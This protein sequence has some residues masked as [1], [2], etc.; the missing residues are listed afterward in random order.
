MC[1]KSAEKPEQHV[2]EEHSLN[3]S[4]EDIQ[5]APSSIRYPKANLYYAF[6]ED[7]HPTTRIAV[8]KSLQREKLPPLV[9]PFNETVQMFS[10]AD[11]AMTHYL[12]T[13]P[14]SFVVFGKPGLNSVDLASAIADAWNCILISPSLLIQEEIDADSE[15]GRCMQKTLEKGEQ[16]A[17]D[18]VMNL[19][20]C[21]IQKRDVRHRGYVVEGL[22]LIPD[23]T[24]FEDGQSESCKDQLICEM[25]DRTVSCHQSDKLA[26]HSV[27]KLQSDYEQQIPQQ[28]DEIFNKLQR[29]PSIIIY[30][31]CPK[32][33]VVIMREHAETAAADTVAED[34]LDEE[35]H[36]PLDVRQDTKE[37]PIVNDDRRNNYSERVPDV[38]RE[39]ELQC[40]LYTRLALPTI[41]KWILAHDP[42]RVIRV[43]GRGSTQRMFQTL[44]ACLRMLPLQPSI[45]PKQMTVEKVN[46]EEGH[47]EIF[48]ILRQREIVSAEFPWRLSAWKFFCPVKLALGQ[49]E[50]RC[51]EYTVRFL[52]YIFFLSSQESV[53]LFIEN[54]RTFLLPPNPQPICKIAVIGP[55]YSGK[56]E[57]S[58][59]LAKVFGGTVI[60]VNELLRN[61]PNNIY[62]MNIDEYD[63]NVRNYDEVSAWLCNAIEQNIK[64]IPREE[65]EDELYKDGGY[66]VD[67]IPIYAWIKIFSKI[68]FMHV[69]VLFEDAYTS[70]TYRNSFVLHTRHSEY[71]NT[72]YEY[73]RDLNKMNKYLQTLQCNTFFINLANIED[74]TENVLDNLRWNFK[75]ATNDKKTETLQGTTSTENNIDEET[76]EDEEE[77][78]SRVVDLE[79]AERLLACGYYFL[80]PFGRWCPVQMYANVIL[81]AHSPNFPFIYQSQIYFLSGEEALLAFS[82]EI[83]KYLARGFRLPA[84]PLRIA[85]IGPPKCGKT[86]LAD[87]FAKTYGLKRITRDIALRH[88]LKHYSWTE[89]AQVAKEK[90]QANQPVPIEC[91]IRAIEALSLGPRAASQGYVLDD[92]PLSREE[93]E[94]LILSGIQPMIVLDLKADLPSCLNCL[95]TGSND[96]TDATVSSDFLARYETWQ[97]H[98]ASFRDWLKKFSRNVVELDAT[99]SKWRVWSVADGAVRL[100][101]AEIA[102]YQ[103]DADLDKVHRLR[104]MCVSPFEFRERQSQ[105]E[106][107][108]PACLFRE[109]VVQASIQPT[110]NQGVV[111]YQEHFYWVCPQHMAA[112]IEDPWQ[113]LPPINTASLPDERLQIL[114]PVIDVEHSCLQRRL[115][116]DGWC[117]VTYVDG[118]AD[119]RLIRGRADLAVLLGEEEVY[120]LCSE[121]CRDKFLARHGDYRNV[122]ITPAHEVD[123]RGLPDILE[124]T[125]VKEV[126]EAV[127]RVAAL[128][129]K[130]VG[131]SAA[132]SAAIHIGVHLKTHHARADANETLVYELADKRMAARDEIVRIVTD[133]VKTRPNPYAEH[134][135]DIGCNCCPGNRECLFD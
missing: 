15:K 75:P 50:D 58:L 81:V 59:R 135:V 53:D 100:R 122:E 78:F 67:G 132:A 79:T 133:I 118:P 56:S 102:L 127:K 106:S 11:A 83:S 49:K 31:V 18:V 22:P 5:Y 25:C 34:I 104:Y 43:D 126:V 1:D 121:E 71:Q 88:V 119:R 124:R 69:V 51:K 41:D 84:L 14:P 110:D 87:R 77:H 82:K 92:C 20:R 32:P 128:R 64:K 91:V 86:T 115:R 73:R 99:D 93:T 130:M 13:D 90:L 37:Q 26:D 96:G 85:I 9:A 72:L 8:S 12:L 107:Y 68:R 17:S 80:S 113:Y 6:A 66:I 40:D 94:Q 108:C 105:Y 3:G 24:S 125:L 97:V 89:S 95:Q 98:Q 35:S 36:P 27:C 21:R 4:Q 117:P 48:E 112:F 23:K 62:Y 76:N 129:P 39:V 19:I 42:R 60:N 57:L 29:K 16:L 131:L 2:A 109:G 70:N 33:D 61:C 63:G 45:L 30:M 55:P 101:F 10:S 28:I 123:P 114:E 7:T 38:R 74:M 46:I 120:L 111:Q 103:R 52:G 44:D 134:A 116:L 65:L 47:E 54:P